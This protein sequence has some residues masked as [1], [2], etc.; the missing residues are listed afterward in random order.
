MKAK[1]SRGWW[2]GVP[3]FGVGLQLSSDMRQGDREKHIEVVFIIAHH[4]S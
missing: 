2:F 4:K 1:V 3:C